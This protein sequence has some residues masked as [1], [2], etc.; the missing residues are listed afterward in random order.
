MGTL[1]SGYENGSFKYEDFDSIPWVGRKVRRPRPVERGPQLRPHEE[2]HRD[3]AGNR[4]NAPGQVQ[5]EP[6]SGGVPRSGAQ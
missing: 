2:Q 1:C 4:Q 5:G 3:P 6:G